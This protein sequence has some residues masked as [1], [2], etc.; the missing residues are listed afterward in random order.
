MN[1]P[2]S[3]FP[4]FQPSVPEG[5]THERMVCAKCDWIHYEN[6]RIIVTGF[7]IWEDQILLCRRAI[8]PRRGFWTLPGG[9]MEI[10][11]TMHEG[12]AREV[13]EEAGSIVSMDS[14][15]ATYTIAR[16]GQVHMVFLAKMDSADYSIGEESLD[17][18]LFPLQ[19]ESLPWD[20][21]A[22][23]VNEWALR[24]YLSL[25]G[26]NVTQPFVVREEDRDVRL[27]SIDCHPDFPLPPNQRSNE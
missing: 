24:D 4:N 21:L 5:D 7:C 16:I 10:G 20:E 18:R 11:E 6:P 23:P 12:A 17:V 8:G 15:L 26:K 9:F 19:H 2:I 14:L 1:I 3:A 27:S 22:F 13:R 25:D